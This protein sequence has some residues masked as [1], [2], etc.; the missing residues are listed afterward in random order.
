MFDFSGLE[1]FGAPVRCSHASPQEETM[2]KKEQKQRDLRIEK[3]YRRTC[4]GVEVNIMDIGKVFK[5]GYAALDAGADDAGLEKAIVDFV[6]TI[7]LN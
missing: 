5:A 1:R 2:T 4:A 3:A 6:A 7:R